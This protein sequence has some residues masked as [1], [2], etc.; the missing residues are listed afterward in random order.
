MYKNKEHLY[1]KVIINPYLD[2]KLDSILLRSSLIYAVETGNFG[3]GIR[4][5][6]QKNVLE[7]VYASYYKIRAVHCQESVIDFNLQVMFWWSHE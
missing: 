5:A 2:P 1:S 6:K 3:S 4:E 7:K